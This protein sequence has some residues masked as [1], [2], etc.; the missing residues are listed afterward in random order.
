MAFDTPLDLERRAW[1]ATQLG[2]AAEFYDRILTSNARVLLREG[3]LS[4]QDAIE[5][6]A[7]NLSWPAYRLHGERVTTITEDITF[8]AYSVTAGRRNEYRAVCSSLF[9][10]RAGTWQLAL[11]QRYG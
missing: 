11:H 2:R 3:P 10:L 9:V 1:R 5:Q 8:V 4:R 7:A 6:W